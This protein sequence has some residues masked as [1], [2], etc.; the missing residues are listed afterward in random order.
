MF[1]LNTEHGN[2]EFGNVNLAHFD[3][4][5]QGKL[6][7]TA[8]FMAAIVDIRSKSI[9]KVCLAPQKP[10]QLPKRKSAASRHFSFHLR[11]IILN[12][13]AHLLLIDNQ[14]HFLYLLK[15]NAPILP[16]SAFFLTPAMHDPPINY[17]ALEKMHLP[18]L[19]ASH[20]LTQADLNKQLAALNI[21]VL[22]TETEH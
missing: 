10:T 19:S 8:D 22:G 20:P 7:V 15:E 16:S 14:A 21:Q 11:T 2:Q 4:S 3:T 9:T 18:Y 17:A 12:N 1:T 13:E 5:R 6:L